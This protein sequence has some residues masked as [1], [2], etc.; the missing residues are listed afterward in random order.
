[1]IIIAIIVQNVCRRNKITTVNRTKI[2]INF[3]WD[4]HSI[5]NY[6]LLIDN[7]L[8]LDTMLQKYQVDEIIHSWPS[9]QVGGTYYN[10][11]MHRCRYDH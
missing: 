6:Y 10:I 8:W 4:Q 3:I 5:Y 11:I 2:I 9:R 7:I 1:M